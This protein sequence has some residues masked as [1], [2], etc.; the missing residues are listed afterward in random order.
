M[1]IGRWDMDSIRC[2]VVSKLNGSYQPLKSYVRELKKNKKPCMKT[3]R[4]LAKNVR[5]SSVALI[6]ENS[7]L[8][9]KDIET[10]QNYGFKVY[11]CSHG[12]YLIFKK[13]YEG[14]CNG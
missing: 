4:W 6:H 1:V 5:N 14:E 8:V 3:L 9:T 7:C 2:Y 10:Y 13:Y 11:I 12:D